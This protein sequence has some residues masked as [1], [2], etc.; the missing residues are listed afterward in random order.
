MRDSPVFLVTI[1]LQG[2]FDCGVV[3]CADGTFAQDDT[4]SYTD[5]YAALDDAIWSLAAA[6]LM[7]AAAIRPTITNPIILS[8]M[9]ATV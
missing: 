1:R 5:P 2:S 7:I 3:R 4:A 6:G 9:V 8:A